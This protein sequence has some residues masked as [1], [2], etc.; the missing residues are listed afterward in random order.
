[1][2]ASAVEQ[3]AVRYGVACGRR[4]V[5]ATACDSGY[6]TA[7]VLKA[8]GMDVAAIVDVRERSGAEAPAGVAV[9]R[10][11]AIVAVAGRR[12]VRSVTIAPQ[13]GGAIQTIAADCI[14]SAGG[15]TPAVN[16]YSMAGGKLRWAAE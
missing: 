10:A 6:R 5:V 3:Y 1:M 2:L 9:H 8:A 14:A 7:Q 13:A 4:I 12:A 11:S 15:W 16:L